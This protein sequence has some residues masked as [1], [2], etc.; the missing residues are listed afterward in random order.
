MTFTFDDSDPDFTPGLDD[1]FLHS[2]ML[3]DFEVQ[4]L[5]DRSFRC[6]MNLV[7]LCAAAR[8][9]TYTAPEP[10]GWVHAG[11]EGL[12]RAVGVSRSLWLSKIKPALLPF[13]EIKDDQLRVAR[14]WFLT[15]TERERQLSMRRSQLIHPGIFSNEAFVSVS[16]S[17]RV[18]LLGLGTLADEAKRFPW[19]EDVIVS[20]LAMPNAAA[21]LA[22]LETASLI[23]R[24]GRQGV[25][26]FDYGFGSGNDGNSGDSED[27]L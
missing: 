10:G 13:L 22:E 27:T 24:E 7:R 26:L 8:A 17:A 23:A 1:I 19:N 18:L 16:T 20:A 11:D 12:A 2:A 3:R 14:D 4:I 25:I 21:E 9:W 6:L 5:D 15:R